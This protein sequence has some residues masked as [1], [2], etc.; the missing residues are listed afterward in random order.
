MLLVESN[1]NAGVMKF[2]GG[3]IWYFRIEGTSGT[4]ANMVGLRCRRILLD[5]M[6]LG[7]VV[8]HN[9]RVQ[10]A[11]PGCKFL[12]AG[13]PDGRRDSMS[14]K[15]D[16][17][18]LGKGWSH[19]KTST[20]INPLYWSTQQ[21]DQLRKAYGGVNSPDYITQVLGQWGRSMLSVFPLES[22]ALH[23]NAYQFTRI[24]GK[25]IPDTIGDAMERIKLAARL[26][27]PRVQSDAF[28][29]GMDYGSKQDPTVIM[30]AYQTGTPGDWIQFVRIEVLGAD[31]IQQ[32][33]LLQ[34]LVEIIGIPRMAK[35]CID[36]ASG[37][38]GVGAA[39]RRI[40]PH[41]QFWIERIVDYNS[42]GK[43]ETVQEI[44]LSEWHSEPGN[45]P[46]REARRHVGRKEWATRIFQSAML[47]ARNNVEAGAIVWVEKGTVGTVKRV[48]CPRIWLADDEEVV[49][50]LA[51]TR[52]R[53][54]ES[55][56]TIYLPPTKGPRYP[57]DHNTDAA[58]CLTLAALETLGVGDEESDD[59]PI[60]MTGGPLFGKPVGLPAVYAGDR[61]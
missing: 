35:V 13:V 27:I 15:L 49:Q 12:Y 59:P 37:G 53:K 4:D 40:T 20:Y 55:G 43:V 11:L 51:A 8:C 17:T 60:A 7:N 33:F 36:L 5:E 14:F 26:K 61:S 38:S 46:S 2:A 42:P 34:Y 32:A 58:R 57:I 41:P 47:A 30:L 50:E 31:E 10:T 23:H 48:N 39:L 56:N 6:Q 54:T 1:K 9:S 24:A 21:R 28:T 16:Q 25:D 44:Q 22:I 3:A 19:H 52:S 45:L 18:D 29:L